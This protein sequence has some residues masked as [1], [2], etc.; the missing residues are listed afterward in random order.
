MDIGGTKSA[1]IDEK[2][3]KLREAPLFMLLNGHVNA[4]LDGRIRDE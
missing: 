3:L 2:L 4:Y 1:N